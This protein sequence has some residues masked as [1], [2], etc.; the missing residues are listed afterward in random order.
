MFWFFDRGRP[1][2][3]AWPATRIR[4][5][6]IVFCSPI[7]ERTLARLPSRVR[8]VGRPR[9]HA[10]LATTAERV[11]RVVLLE[12]FPNRLLQTFGYHVWDLTCRLTLH[13]HFLMH[14]YTGHQQFLTETRQS[15][16][17]P[18]VR[19]GSQ[20]VRPVPRIGLNPADPNPPS[21]A[22]GP[23]FEDNTL[24]VLS[25][26]PIAPRINFEN[27]AI[28]PTEHRHTARIRKFSH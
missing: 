21:L 22:P 19:S 3:A 24:H 6:T 26:S 25:C 17:K 9:G 2:P 27:V 13:E 20:F 14:D 7:L 12:L 11:H 4:K 16:L 10:K 15:D 23:K 8:D 5:E 18:C 28:F 1:T